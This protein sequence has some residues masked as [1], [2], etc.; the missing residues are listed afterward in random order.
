MN[1]ESI[2]ERRLL[3]IMNRNPL[4][5]LKGY[6]PLCDTQKNNIMK[7]CNCCSPMHQFIFNELNIIYQIKL[8]WLTQ[9]NIDY[10]FEKEMKIHVLVTKKCRECKINHTSKN[11][12]Y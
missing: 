3:A 9:E 2:F 8:I 4:Y 11:F 5:V 10:M 12:C 1:S 7:L 6:C